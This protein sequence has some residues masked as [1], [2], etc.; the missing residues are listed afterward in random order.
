MVR[1]SLR[2]SSATF[3]CEQGMMR[4]LGKAVRVSISWP[5]P[6]V[7]LDRWTNVCCFS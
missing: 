6:L 7:N 5:Q 1:W 3:P 2:L 4:G